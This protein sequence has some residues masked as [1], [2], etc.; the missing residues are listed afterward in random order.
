MYNAKDLS[1][2]SV[3]IDSYRFVVSNIKSLVVLF[4]PVL[5]FL[6]A[7]ETVTDASGGYYFLISALFDLFFYPLI[8]AVFIKYVAQ[9]WFQ[10]PVAYREIVNESFMIWWPVFQVW[11]FTSAAVALGFLLLIVPGI[12]VAI[13]LSFSLYYTVIVR[14]DPNTSLKQSFYITKDAFWVILKSASFFL[15]PVLLIEVVLQSSI[16]NYVMSS[17]LNLVLITATS[18]YYLI[19]YVVVFRVFMV[20]VLLETNKKKED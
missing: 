3:V 13:R 20:T 14:L 19:W 6:S 7:V 12:W 8:I 15:V 5:L 17:I 16:D 18:F 9:R 4:V 10:K 11:F 1:S 2:K